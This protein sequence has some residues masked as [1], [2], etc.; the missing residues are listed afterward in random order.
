MRQISVWVRALGRPGGGW[1]G[2]GLLGCGAPYRANFFFGRTFDLVSACGVTFPD[3]SNRNSVHPVWE[4]DCKLN[5]FAPAPW[6]R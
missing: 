1:S 4:R 6:I 2:A 5:S 3:T